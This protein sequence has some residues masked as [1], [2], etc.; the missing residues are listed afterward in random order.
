M[1]KTFKYLNEL[2]KKNDKV[3]VAVSGGPDSMFLLHLLCNIKKNKNYKLIVAH[4]NHNVRKESADEKLKIE[5]YCKINNIIFEYL[6][7]E[8]YPKENFHDYA[9]KVRYNFFDNIVNKYKAKY[10][11]T[12]HH[13]DDLME[14]ILMRIVRGSS[15]NG[16]SGFNKI[17]KYK[18]YFIVRPLIELTKQEINDYMDIHKLWYAI[19]N[20]NCKDVY[21]RN[22]FRKYV[23]PQLKK[24]NP[25]VHLKF[26]SLSE[27][28]NDI[29]NFL[30]EYTDKVISRIY[31][32]K[33]INIQQFI[34]EKKAITDIIL[35]RILL[36][37]YHDKICLISYKNIGNIYKVI[38]SA[39]SNMK[40]D[41]PLDFEFIKS[42]NFCYL[43]K[44]NYITDYK[45]EIN[46]LVKLDNGRQIEKV[47]SCNLTD[48]NVIYLNS[49]NLNLPLYVRNRKIGDK[50][51]IKNFNHYKKVKDIFIE[52]KISLAERDNYPIVVD[53]SDEIIWIPGLK[54]SYFDSKNDKKYDI[55]LKYY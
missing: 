9:R 43:K 10:L 51:K 26:L 36:D 50:I 3:V 34:I 25:N 19:D 30:E 53:S 7:I 5:D 8:K 2:I 37:N 35:Y 47:K 29:S 38:T 28:I 12:A 24:E 45:I 11:L 15:F 49:D 40:I 54:K 27:K 20:S 39:K 23:V 22:R 32:D 42:Y 4:I 6:K 46:D 33:K 41:L 17:S 14:T 52:A 18:N 21:T 48:N 1:D 55:I 31:Y 44:K 16:Y 13:G